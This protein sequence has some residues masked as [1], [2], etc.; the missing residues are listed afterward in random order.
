MSAIMQTSLSR[1]DST[2]QSSTW[3]C[4][5]LASPLKMLPTDGSRRKK[6]WLG[7]K[8]PS[9]WP[10]TI[11]TWVE[12]I[13]LTNVWQCTPT[14]VET[15]GGTSRCF[16][17]VF[18]LDVTIVNAWRL[19]LMSGLEKIRLLIF[20]A[21]VAHALINSGTLQQSKRGRPSG[22]PPQVKRRAVTKVACE[23]RFGTGN[24]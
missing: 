14:D 9:L 23:V 8:N 6:R 10:F 18:F 16:F 19:Y 2:V 4:P 20:K 5:V 11:N 22:T 1:V 13:L 17:F 7:S 15:S 12:L 24:Y 21:S 3:S